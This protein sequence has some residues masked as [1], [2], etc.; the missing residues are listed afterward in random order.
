[1]VAAH[2]LGAVWLEGLSAV[3]SMLWRWA[4]V[5]LMGLIEG[6]RV[7]GGPAGE[8]LDPLYP[9]EAF[10]P[11]GLADD[12]DTFA[13]LKV[14]ELKNGRLAMFSMFGFFLQVRCCCCCSAAPRLGVLVCAPLPHCD[15]AR[16]HSWARVFCSAVMCAVPPHGALPRLLPRLLRNGIEMPALVVLPLQGVATA[17]AFTL[18][19]PAASTF[20][21]HA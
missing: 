21:Q 9:G 8:G 10:D 1:M 18:H 13:E 20:L 11:L 7:N 6:Y 4:Q 15:V 19:C 2:V 12:P 17:V 5:I 16:P 14:K 3:L